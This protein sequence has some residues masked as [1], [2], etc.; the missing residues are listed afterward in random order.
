MFTGKNQEYFLEVANDVLLAEKAGSDAKKKFIDQRLLTTGTDFFDTIKKLELLTMETSKKYTKL[1]NTQGNLVKYKEQADIAF[2]ILVKC[3]ALT[4]PISID[5][6]MTYSITIVP[7][8]LGTPDGFLFKT[9][10]S[11][12]V[13]Y[14]T[15]DIQTPTFPPDGE[16][17]YVEDGDA[18]MYT[19]SD[20]PSNFRLIAIKV[21]DVLK[22][23]SNVVFSTD[24]HFPQSV[25]SSE[26]V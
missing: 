12:I 24:M 6:L 25:K 10:K 14:L 18:L 17:L 4:K 9:D 1:T 26:R 22:K 23:K 11:K 2:Q 3:Q 20:I 15:K 5:E 7:H 16:T 21:L 19:L 8:S 13:K